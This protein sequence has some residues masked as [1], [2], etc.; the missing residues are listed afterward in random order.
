LFPFFFFSPSPGV[1]AQLALAVALVRRPRVE[2]LPQRLGLPRRQITP[3]LGVEE[4]AVVRLEVEVVADAAIVAE[5]VLETGGV[6][7]V[8]EVVIGLGYLLGGDLAASSRRRLVVMVHRGG[9][10]L[11]RRLSETHLKRRHGQTWRFTFE[12]CA[13][14]GGAMIYRTLET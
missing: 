4:R 3:Q 8:F 6:E 7:E 14:Y 13:D 11:S 9:G 2:L 5:Y 1:G 10:G 12:S